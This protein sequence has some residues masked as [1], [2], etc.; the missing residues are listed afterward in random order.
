MRVLI[1]G[2]TGLTGSHVAPYLSEQ[3][4]HVVTL[5]SRDVNLADPGWHVCSLPSKVDAIVHL[6]QD[7]GYRRFPD[8]AIETVR[9][10]VESTVRLLDYARQCGAR[11]FVL[12]S[13]GG[14]YRESRELLTPDSPILR[15]D[16]AS[17]YFASKIAAESWAMNY[18]D[19]FDV[20]VLRLFTV[21]GCGA[22]PDT[23]F[24]RLIER[25][26][27]SE[28]VDL[29]GE[30]GD[31]LRPTHA[32]DVGR[33]V[34]AC[35]EHSGSRTIDVGGPE[36]IA[37]KDL[38]NRIGRWLGVQPSFNVLDAAPRVLA[39]RLDSLGHLGVVP[40]IGVEEGLRLWD[41]RG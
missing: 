29:H 8:A 37:V 16:E 38:A 41:D 28:R 26:E 4:C 25:M 12:A 32:L 1:T 19:Y 15:P 14:V 33:T 18:R 11:A 36:V 30:D 20:S 13:T 23:L 21:Y 39:P 17:P 7:R 3:G 35:L 5:S 24:P 10:N 34:W 2:A 6:A 22:N 27:R 40:S 9:V 31:L